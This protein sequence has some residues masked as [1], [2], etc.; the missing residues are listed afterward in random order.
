MAVNK[1]GF[2]D[3][4]FKVKYPTL[5][6]GY[7]HKLW[8]E[9]LITAGYFD[10]TV[11]YTYG[12]GEIVE[13]VKDDGKNYIVKPIDATT[14]AAKPLAVIMN[15]ITGAET[16][17]GGTI[18]KGVKQVPLN[19]WIL[20]GKI[21]NGTVIVPVVEG[22]TTKV[23]LGGQVYIGTGANGTIAGSAY[24]QN[25][26]GT[27]APTGLIFTSKVSKPTAAAGLTAAIGFKL[28]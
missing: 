28:G 1:F 5:F 6:A 9:R 2:G 13:L 10:G 20:D 17:L 22:T 24:S 14:T 23:A 26:T 8:G 19:L 16:V 11:D 18:N 12:F 25:V 4:S 15:E 21:N 27:I 3:L 7:Q